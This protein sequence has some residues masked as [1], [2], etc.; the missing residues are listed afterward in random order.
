M[1][2]AD[3]YAGKARLGRVFWLGFVLPFLPLVAGI[4]MTI[5][6]RLQIGAWLT[7]FILLVVYEWWLAVSLWRCSPN[8]SRPIYGQLARALS[9]MIVLM[10]F[11]AALQQ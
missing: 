5:G 8:T 4:G 11:T 7:V 9:I 2:I 1:W 6:A 10:V 3:A